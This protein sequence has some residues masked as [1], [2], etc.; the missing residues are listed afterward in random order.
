M[1]WISIYQNMAK[2]TMDP[3]YHLKILWYFHFLTGFLGN[4][5]EDN[6]KEYK[7]LPEWIFDFLLFAISIAKKG[8]KC[9][10]SIFAPLIDYK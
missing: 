4:F 8:P 2:L 5:Q 9:F 6:S 10:S 3:P 7:K 1:S